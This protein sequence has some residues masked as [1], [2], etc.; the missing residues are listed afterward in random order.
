MKKTR[1]KYTLEFKILTASKSIQSG[2]VLEMARELN[3]SADTL[4]HWKKFYKDGS[5]AA[6]MHPSCDFDKKE[7]ITMRRQIKELQTECAILKKAQNIFSKNGGL[8]MNLSESMPLLFPLGRCAEF[9]R[10]IRPAFTDGRKDCL[11]AEPCG[12][13]SSHL[14][15]PGFTTGASA[16]TA[17]LELPKNYRQ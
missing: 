17:A 16:D 11:P 10:S 3:I 13:F 8:N 14:K 6:Q 2:K 15:L 5:F 4:Q 1:K 12:K 9:F 7:R